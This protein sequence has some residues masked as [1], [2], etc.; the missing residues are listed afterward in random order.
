MNGMSSKVDERQIISELELARQ[1]LYLE[2][3][4]DAYRTLYDEELDQIRSSLND[5]RKKLLML[6][7]AKKK[8]E[9]LLMSLDSQDTDEPDK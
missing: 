2:Q 8:D 4:L 1:L 6:M 9:G 5:C 3:Q 7:S